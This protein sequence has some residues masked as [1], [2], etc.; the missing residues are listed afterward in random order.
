MP[1]MVP[2]A[3]PSKF[4]SSQPTA[5]PSILPSSQPTSNPSTALMIDL[6]FTTSTTI[7]SNTL[8]KSL[9]DNIDI[10]QDYIDM[11]KSAIPD[12]T[13]CDIIIISV[14]DIETAP[15]NKKLRV[16]QRELLTIIKVTMLI[17]VSITSIGYED[18]NDAFLFLTQKVDT[19]VT[20]NHVFLSSLQSSLTFNDISGLEV[21]YADM[22]FIMIHSSSPSQDPTE[23]PLFNEDVSFMDQNILYIVV[24]I[25]SLFF[26]IGYRYYYKNIYLKKIK[27]QSVIPFKEDGETIIDWDDINPIEILDSG[28]HGCVFKAKYKKDEVAIKLLYS[29]NSYELHK[30]CNVILKLNQSKNVDKR[31]VIHL[32]GI[33]QGAITNDKMI[34]LAKQSGLSIR[35]NGFYE[36]IVLRFEKGGSLESN[37]K[38][39]SQKSTCEKL[40]LLRCIAKTLSDLHDE[41][42]DY[43]IHGD[44][45]PGNI[46]FSDDKFKIPVLADFG[47]AK[48]KINKGTLINN[49]N[50]I[51]S[52]NHVIKGTIRYMAPEMFGNLKNIG[53]QATRKTDI[54]AFSLLCYEVLSN[55][56][57]Y[58]DYNVDNLL[59]LFLDDSLNEIDKR[60]DLKCLHDIDDLSKV[61]IEMISDCWDIDPE[62]RWNSCRMFHILDSCYNKLA[63][64]KFDLFLSHP[65]NSKGCLRQVYRQLSRQNFTIWYDEENMGHDI[66]NSMKK[67]IDSSK[68]VLV[69]ADAP[70]DNIPPGHCYEQRDNCMFELEYAKQE[71]KTIITILIGSVDSNN[72]P[73]I[74]QIDNPNSYKLEKY[75]KKFQKCIGGWELL[76]IK[77]DKVY[78]SGNW[79]M[80]K[81]HITKEMIESLELQMKELYKLLKDVGCETIN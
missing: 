63:R 65:W 6:I 57:P 72:P 24:I 22:P 76:H 45:K 59:F 77:F 62:K 46:L 61:I 55:K 47:I 74:Q 21:N 53:I 54:Y 5:Q 30:E 78:A 8:S 17:T 13:N 10:K 11:F 81:D 58:H 48:E 68:V 51:N 31:H 34:S 70:Q 50:I 38:I 73:T 44:L 27:R 20:T 23:F 43:I 66:N 3:Q 16:N 67:G 35:R 75:S 12:L 15:S 29:Q 79:D 26:T 56:S 40:Q 69:F 9:F 32:Y 14:I 39:I 71:N 36:A 25:T 33:L 60:P 42:P 28:S 64:E 52:T 4:P 49:T 80:N 7:T 18:P 1:S 2:S 37:M 19:D 41:R